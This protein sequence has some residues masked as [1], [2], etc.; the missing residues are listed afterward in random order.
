VAPALAALAP[1]TVGGQR[2]NKAGRTNAS[3]F[4]TFCIALLCWAGTGAAPVAAG[5]LDVGLGF[6]LTRDSNVNQSSTNPSA[7]WT[8]QLF[9]GFGYQEIGAELNARAV[10]QVERRHFLRNSF[11]DDN[12]FFFDGSGVWTIS[13]RRFTWTVEDV[14][15]E[16][17][18]VASAPNTPDNRTK[19]NSL[20]TGPEF[21]FRVD[22]ANVPVIGA[23]YGRFYI[24]GPGGN[25]RYTLY[26]RWLHQM[27]AP[28]T[29]SLN[30]EAT[31]AHFDPPAL[32]T[33]LSRKDL[34][35]RYE[36][37]QLS[38]RQ[39]IDFGTTR[40]AQY[41]GEDL[42]GRLAR[43]VAELLPT[44]ESALR[45]LL[46]DQ[47]SD[48][49]SDLIRA[50]ITPTTTG[51]QADAVA[52]PFTVANAAAGDVYHSQR[53]EFAYLRRGEPLGY[54]LQ[55][56][57]QRVDYNT[58]PQ[59]YRERGG[60][61]SLSWLL[62]V[63]AQAYAYTQYSRRTFSSIEEHDADRNKGVGVVYKLGRALSL[64]VE[65]GQIERQST[66]P[67][68]TF[69]DRRLMLILGYSTGP[70]YSPRTRR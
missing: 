53:G 70:L 49:Y 20:N 29:L 15:R 40:L 10:G 51:I 32:Y 36:V 38:N 65:A 61:F 1:S 27:S 59:D 33:D 55:A 21:V 25:Q 5:Q 48:T 69:V 16:I 17:N 67:E 24:D 2:V 4:E 45:L 57:A 28:T 35:L 46:T 63:E 42:S 47:I 66:V 44:S 14:Y 13:P 37:L 39:T 64:T 26:A 34:F 8:E 43:Y 54:T 58:L 41:G 3:R 9:G 56:Y 7:D 60:R 12:G 62:S 23:R 6:A 18:L 31:R 50:A 52:V 11:Q 22:P 68:A 30:F 19:T